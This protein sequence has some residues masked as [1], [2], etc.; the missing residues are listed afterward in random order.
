M[1]PEMIDRLKDLARKDCWYDDEYEDK[2]VYDYSGSNVDDAFALGE[3]AGETMMAR[4]VLRDMGI[5]WWE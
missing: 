5:S 2:V 4:E 3:A 1:T